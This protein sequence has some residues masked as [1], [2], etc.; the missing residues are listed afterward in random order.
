[1]TSNFATKNVFAALVA[2]SEDEDEKN[3]TEADDV[4]EDEDEKDETDAEDMYCFR[5]NDH[6]TG[7]KSNVFV[8]VDILWEDFAAMLASRFQRPDFILSDV[9]AM[10][11]VAPCRARLTSMICASTSMLNRFRDYPWWLVRT[12]WKK[13]EIRRQ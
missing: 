10:N 5:C 8:D 9:T 11:T 4:S 2:E 1:M 13:R 6:Q 3:E 12:F 7:Q